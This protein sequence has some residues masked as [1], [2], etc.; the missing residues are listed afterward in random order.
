MIEKNVDRKLANRIRYQIWYKR[1]LKESFVG[2]SK[3]AK[4]DVSII[5]KRRNARKQRAHMMRAVQ[6]QV[7][8]HE[9]SYSEVLKS[10]WWWP[11]TF[12]NFFM[13]LINHET[14]WRI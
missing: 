13:E 11:I 14:V 1:C 4:W 2:G 8:A 9:L 5:L 3:S 7:F 6:L 10:G 12:V